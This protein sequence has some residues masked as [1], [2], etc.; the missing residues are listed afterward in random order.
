MRTQFE[1][2]QEEIDEKVARLVAKSHLS[3]TDALCQVMK[4]RALYE[5]YTQAA[6]D[7]SAP[8][9]TPLPSRAPST[10]TEKRASDFIPASTQAAIMKTADVL[11][12]G[13]YRKGM[14]GIEAALEEMVQW[15]KARGAA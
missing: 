7:P 10:P 14:R 1:Q 6:A 4:D 8:V 3:Q 15:A 12:P 5:R 2:I 13:D 11:S 9:P